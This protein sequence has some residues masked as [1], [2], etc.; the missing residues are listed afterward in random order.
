[1]CDKVIIIKHTTEHISKT[2]RVEKKIEETLK[3]FYSSGNIFHI[4]VVGISTQKKRVEQ[5]KI[6][7]YSFHVTK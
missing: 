2:P 4:S 1:M 6:S 7:W 3:S 5:Q